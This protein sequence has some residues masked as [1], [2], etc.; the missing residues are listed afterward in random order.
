MQMHWH[1]GGDLWCATSAP[2]V[3]VRRTPGALYTSDAIVVVAATWHL[4]ATSCERLADYWRL[5]TNRH[6][7]RRDTLLLATYDPLPTTYDL[8][9]IDEHLLPKACHRLRIA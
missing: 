7:L 6:C 8:R 4:L 5:A 3:S 1:D 9:P 2:Y